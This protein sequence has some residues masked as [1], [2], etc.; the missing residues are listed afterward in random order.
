MFKTVLGVDA[1]EAEEWLKDPVS[2]IQKVKCCGA[3]WAVFET[4][5]ARDRAVEKVNGSGGLVLP[6]D[7][8]SGG[9]AL[10]E[11]AGCE[12]E[13]V[14]WGAFQLR[15]NGDITVSLVKG[16]VCILIALFL[17][18]F[19][20]YIPFAYYSVQLASVTGA[21][22]TNSN[23]YHT[24]THTHMV[25][26]ETDQRAEEAGWD[27]AQVY[28]TITVVLGNQLMYYACD[29]VADGVGFRYEDQKM[30]AYVVLY[31][32][33]CFVNVLLD[34]VINYGTLL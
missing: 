28:F 30:A 23:T 11:A 32:L 12:P 7:G 2:E 13:T 8:E 16:I 21:E 4:E 27:V 31:T 3:A 33:A 10:M 34:L 22:E 25:R 6:S 18:A 19:V 5:E 26:E 24:H 9:N 14:R 1:E 17:W 15:S 20:F 29:Q